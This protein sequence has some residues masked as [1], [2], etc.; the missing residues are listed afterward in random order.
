[1]Q[2]FINE[3]AFDLTGAGG[4]RFPFWPTSLKSAM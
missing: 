3:I 4:K 1:M 2:G